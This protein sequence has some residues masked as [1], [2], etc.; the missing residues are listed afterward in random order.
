MQYGVAQLQW[1]IFPYAV[2]LSEGCDRFSPQKIAKG[3][4]P[5]LRCTV[6]INLCGVADAAALPGRFLPIDS[7]A[8][9]AR[10]FFGP[11]SGRAAA[12]APANRLHYKR[13]L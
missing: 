3:C 11:S 9:Y 5:L 2:R 7:A 4:C 13:L 8:L 6:Y 12:G 10:L 1:T